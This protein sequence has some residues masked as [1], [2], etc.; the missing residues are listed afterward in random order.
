ML[1]MTT[2]K[3]AIDALSDL[4]HAARAT[5]Q[6]AGFKGMLRAQRLANRI[7]RQ[8]DAAR[9]RLVQ[10]GPGELGTVWALVDTARAHLAACRLT[11]ARARRGITL[12]CRDARHAAC[13]TCD[14]E[15]HA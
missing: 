2:T 6:D 9:T 12:D 5:E 14:C 7:A 3:P 1:T 8:C 4:V 15:C 11:V 10:D 13:D